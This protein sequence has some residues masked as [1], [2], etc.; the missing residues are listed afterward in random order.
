MTFVSVMGWE[1]RY[2]GL[3]YVDGGRDWHGVDCWGLVRLALMEERGS[4][5]PAYGEISARD[6]L[7]IARAMEHGK[8]AEVWLAVDAPQ[9]LD[10]LV[11][12]P[13]GR[14]WVGHVGIMVDGRTV[15]HAEA[16]VNACLVPVDHWSIAHRIIGFRRHK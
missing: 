6:M 15:L 1:A 2:V 12:R 16:G 8:D 13:A 10:V 9:A 14:S 4:G 3:P 5:L 7:R 11:M